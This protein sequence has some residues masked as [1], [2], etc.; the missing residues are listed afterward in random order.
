MIA[1]GSWRSAVW[2]YPARDIAPARRR[3]PDAFLTGLLRR[4]T[5]E[6]LA[7][8]D[9]MGAALREPLT[10]N[11]ILDRLARAGLKRIA[12]LAAQPN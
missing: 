5:R 9:A 2:G 8:I 11:D 7:T 1:S 10:R 3:D 4:H 6:V 12:A